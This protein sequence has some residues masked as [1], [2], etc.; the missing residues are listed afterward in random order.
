[1]HI[2]IRGVAAVKSSLGLS[3]LKFEEL[4]LTSFV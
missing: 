1:M 2:N 4:E 3:S